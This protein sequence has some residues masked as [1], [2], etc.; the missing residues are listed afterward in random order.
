MTSRSHE[1]LL[2]KHAKRPANQVGN[3]MEALPSAFTYW[4]VSKSALASLGAILYAQSIPVM[5]GKLVEQFERR[6]CSHAYVRYQEGM[7]PGT[8]WTVRTC[9]PTIHCIL[10]TF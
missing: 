1:K 6:G 4:I 3:R 9:P 10:S 2:A 5:A 8:L 7:Q